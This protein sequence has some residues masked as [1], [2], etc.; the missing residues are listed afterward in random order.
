VLN[1][2][3]VLVLRALYVGGRSPA[4]FWLAASVSFLGSGW[5][6]LALLPLLLRPAWRRGIAVLIAALIA[7]S[8]V[9]AGLKLLVGRTRPVYALP[10]AHVLVGLQLPTDHSFPSGHAAGSFAFAT[11]VGE[12]SPRHRV[13]LL[14]LASAIGVS[15]VALGVHYPSDVVA[16]ALLGA[17]IGYVA[18]RVW[19]RCD[20]TRPSLGADRAETRWTTRRNSSKSG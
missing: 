14:L 7:T 6:L 4:W 2:V 16:G 18:A 10:W 12:V 8:A 3:D 17:L 20:Q 1:D 11:F 13:R 19:P 9:V 5:M 15:R